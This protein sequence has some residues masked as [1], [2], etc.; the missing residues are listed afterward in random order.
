MVGRKTLFF[1]RANKEGIYLTNVEPNCPDENYSKN[2][3][4]KA[5]L[6]DIKIM[7]RKTSSAATVVICT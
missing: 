1:K 5:N 2:I 4:G 3:V 7:V 6:G